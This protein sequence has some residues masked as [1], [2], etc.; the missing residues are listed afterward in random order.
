LDRFST[1]SGDN[2][3]RRKRLLKF[4]IHEVSSVRDLSQNTRAHEIGVAIPDISK[5]QR[6]TVAKADQTLAEI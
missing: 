4:C 6:A 2:L 5:S 3:E 1:T